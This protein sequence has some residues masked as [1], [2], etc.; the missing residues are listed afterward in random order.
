MEA[1]KSGGRRG[2]L[3][4]ILAQHGFEVPFAHAAGKA[5][6]PGVGTTRTRVKHAGCDVQLHN[7]EIGRRLCANAQEAD[8]VVVAVDTPVV[9]SGPNARALAEE[10][11]VAGGRD[12]LHDGHLLHEILL[13][14]HASVLQH[15]ERVSGQ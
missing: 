5:R 4:P 8:N 1:E 12:I 13:G 10:Q 2:N 15:L 6:R 11:M 9:G 14:V 7:H 3:W